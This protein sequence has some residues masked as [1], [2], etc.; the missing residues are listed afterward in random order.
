MIIWAIIISQL[1]AYVTFILSQ[2]N[3]FDA[4][5]A[6]AGLSLLAY[7][8]FTLID[9]NAQMYSTVFFGATF[10]GM[11]APTRFSNKTIIV[12]ALFF[13]LFFIYLVPLLKGFGG[14]LGLSSFLSICLTHSLRLL[15]IKFAKSVSA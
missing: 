11:S 14:A 7:G 4:I 1:G 6:S 9:I 3:R 8:I 2:R 12:S 5:R 10:I 13:A 15:I